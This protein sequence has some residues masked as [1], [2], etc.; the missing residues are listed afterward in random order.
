MKHTF[1]PW[2]ILVAGGLSEPFQAPLQGPPSSP[3]HTAIASDATGIISDPFKVANKTYYDY[4]VAGGGL[5]GLTVAA[6]L[7]DHP[8]KFNVLVIESGFYGSEYGPIIDDL[9]TY[10]QIFGSSVDH[11]YETSPQIHKRVEIV[12]SGNG[13]GG[14]TLIN[15][16]TWTRPHRDQVN[17]WEEIFGNSGWNWE[18]LK[19]YM[20]G[21][22]KPRDPTHATVTEGSNHTYEPGCHNPNPKHGKVEVGA[23]DQKTPWSPL[24]S[25][26]MQTANH[27]TGAPMRQDLCCGQPHGVSMFLNTLTN[28]Q[29]RTDAERSWLDPILHNTTAKARITV[30]TGQLVG[31]VNLESTNQSTKGDD[32]KYRATGVEFG[33]HR[34]DGWN[35]NVTAKQEVLLAAG[36]TISPIILQY[37]GIGPANVLKAPKV[38]IEPKIDL[39]VGLNLQDQTTTTVISETTRE[40][41]GQGQAAYFATFAEVFGEHAHHYEAILNNN[42]TLHKWAHETVEGGGFQDESALFLQYVN[43]QNWL[44]GK[45]NVTYAELFMDTSNHIH[46]DLWNLLPFTRGYVKILDNDPYLR[47][48]EYNPRYF[49]NKLDL[50]GQAAASKLARN[51][52]RSGE[53]EKFFGQETLPGELLSDDATLDAWALYV[54]QNFRPNYHGV[55]TCSMM[56]KELGG[57]VDNT[58]KVYGVQNL[59]VVDGSIPPT[60]VSAHVMTLFYAMAS[61]IGDEI[62]HA[63][64]DKQ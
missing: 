35:F 31:K 38:N 7:I 24:I 64:D 4:V 1:I 36:S 6:K 56:K 3:T 47:S 28:D 20:D 51:L 34:K 30:L 9:N 62:L 53:M 57:V 40:G 42:E 26:L 13:L 23:R 43:Y 12:R 5:T 59:R 2:L 32:P 63:Y 52:T 39:P 21:I 46:F 55:G 11:A 29:I 16:G 50:Y 18:G 33:T 48:F 27:T 61:K 8:A 37:S 41:N 58:A 44:L 22:E 60:Q 25:A 45:N 15:G 19:E 14:S 17:S 54:K 10:G 49:E